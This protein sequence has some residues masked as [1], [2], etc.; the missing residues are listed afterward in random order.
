MNYPSPEPPWVDS[1][2]PAQAT[3]TSPSTMSA[4][5]MKT[6]SWNA[7]VG[8]QKLPITF[9]TVRKAARHLHSHGEAGRWMRFCDLSQ[10][11]GISMN[12]YRGLTFTAPYAWR[13]KI[14]LPLPRNKNSPS[15][16]L[17]SFS[18]SSLLPSSPECILPFRQAKS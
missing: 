12:G 13:T 6:P 3:E 14:N 15:P 9:T 1:W 2:R 11:Q 10:E 8:A 5:D 4:S 17:T 16:F 18:P 7:P